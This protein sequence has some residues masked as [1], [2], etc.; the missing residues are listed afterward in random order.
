[1]GK[2]NIEKFKQKYIG[3]KY[4]S[5][6]K[7]EFEIIDWFSYY[8]VTIKFE[9]GT[10]KEHVSI[11]SIRNRSVKHPECPIGLTKEIFEQVVTTKYGW[12]IKIIKWRS[13]SDID[14][15]FLYDGAIAKN[16]N[17]NSF[18]NK[19]AMHPIH[20]ETY[21]HQYIERLNK[22]IYYNG[23]HTARILNYRT[24]SD[25]DV[26]F[27]DGFI[28]YNTTYYEFNKGSLRRVN[29]EKSDT[30]KYDMIAK[31]MFKSY[32]KGAKSR[33]LDFELSY[34]EFKDLIFKKCVYC[35]SEGDNNYK[36][37]KKYG[38]VYNGIDRI[39]SNIGYVK[40]NV[41]TC[42]TICNHGKSDFKYD[43][44]VDHLKRLSEYYYDNHDKIINRIKGVY[45][46][47]NA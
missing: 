31:R 37:Q 29:I 38:I 14:I 33:N 34:E 17:Y 2:T 22:V 16:K 18:K 12:D 35:G 19:T 27:D 15:L 46:N 42:C 7:Y 47:H 39:D 4:I 26:I 1:M 5:N 3:K 11:S 25:I 28:W 13:K 32:Q 9:D 10:I 23:G 44:W 21:F 20:C 45:E 30:D 24:S 43:D 6:Q 36:K 41:V 8:D 40:G